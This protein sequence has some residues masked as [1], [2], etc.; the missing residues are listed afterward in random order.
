M[1]EYRKH[2]ASVGVPGN[3]AYHYMAWVRQYAEFCDDRQLDY[4]AEESLQDYL[5]G[6]GRLNADWKVV[7]S[8]DVIREYLLQS[9]QKYSYLIND[10]SNTNIL[11]EL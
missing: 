1:K 2:L 7:Q 11:Y 4:W 9:L 6:N 5:L 3:Q 8:E 10:L